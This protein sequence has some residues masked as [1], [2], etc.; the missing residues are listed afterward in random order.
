MAVGLFAAT[1]PNPICL[2]P[3]YLTCKAP[4]LTP[5]LFNKSKQKQQHIDDWISEHRNKNSST[6]FQ[7]LLPKTIV[8]HGSSK[9]SKS[10]FNS[11]PLFIII[12]YRYLTEEETQ[13]AHT[14]L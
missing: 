1:N 10:I 13:N 4:N 8:P 12:R 2:I 11:E 9:P 3:S 14:F 5:F 6:S 7:N